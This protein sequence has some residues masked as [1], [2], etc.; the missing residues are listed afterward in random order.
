MP[1][2]ALPGVV[3]QS[4][5]HRNSVLLKRARARRPLLFRIQRAGMWGLILGAVIVAAFPL[6]WTLAT[7]LKPIEDI[8]AYPPRF[9]PETVTFENYRDVATQSDMPQYFVHSIVVTAVTIVLT[10]L[11]ATPAGYAAARYRFRGKNLLLFLLL[12]TVMIPGAVI[13]VP[14]YVLAGRLALL[15]TYLVLVLVYTAWRVPMVLWI[16][17]SFFEAIPVEMEEAALVDGCG[18]LQAMWRVAFPLSWPGLSASAIL[19][20]VYVWT[21]FI[22]AL[23]LTS[24]LR[25]VTVG[26]YY[27]MTGYGIEWGRLTASVILALVPVLIAFFFFQKR[28]MQGLTAGALK[29]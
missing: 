18:R 29:G 26:L 22:L 1:P 11:L 9:F 19:V 15:D 10:L 12:S 21:E 28:F 6:L 23:T 7:S 16:M 17:K 20:L 25:T 4:A 14:L 8:A 13:M 2:G 5:I 3:S 27:Y 24:K